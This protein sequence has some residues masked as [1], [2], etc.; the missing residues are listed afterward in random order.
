LT[1]TKSG[2]SNYHSVLGIV[3][4]YYQYQ[5]YFCYL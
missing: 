1:A 5:W 2:D 3:I 4:I